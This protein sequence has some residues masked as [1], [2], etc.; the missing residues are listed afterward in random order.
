[1]TQ[2]DRWLIPVMGPIG[3]N[4]NTRHILNRKCMVGNTAPGQPLS[5]CHR[6]TWWAEP[7]CCQ[8]RSH[9][10]SHACLWVLSPQQ[11]I[12]FS[13][14]VLLVIEL[15]VDVLFI[16]VHCVLN[17]KFL[18]NTIT[19]KICAIFHGPVCFIEIEL[20]PTRRH[21]YNGEG[22]QTC[23]TPQSSLLM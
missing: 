4:Q 20:T 8:V 12:E 16:H 7:H 14:D 6:S 23:T 13:V 2:L 17:H 3:L 5:L 15:S 10:A 21:N 19:L 18:L 22:F 1:M 9:K 11:V